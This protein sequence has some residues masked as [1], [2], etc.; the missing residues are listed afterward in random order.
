M[1]IFDRNS[2]PYPLSECALRAG[3]DGDCCLGFPGWTPFGYHSDTILDTVNQNCFSNK[4]KGYL[5]LDMVDAI[6]TNSYARECFLSIYKYTEKQKEKFSHARENL[7][8]W[9]PLYPIKKKD[10]E[11]KGL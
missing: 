3:G 7:K 8:K 4:T 11:N 5:C 1:A 6:I 10:K 9:C 2:L